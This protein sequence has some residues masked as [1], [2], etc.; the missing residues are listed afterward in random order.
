M[1][2]WGW[3]FVRVEFVEFLVGEHWPVGIGWLCYGH[4]QFVV[5]SVV[6][7]A[8]VAEGVEH[9]ALVG[10]L[11]VEGLAC[12]DVHG[13]ECEEVLVDVVECCWE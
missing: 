2:G 10:E 3:L 13:V 4:D 5:A 7:V 9:G 11:V 12:E 1:G 8:V 6:V